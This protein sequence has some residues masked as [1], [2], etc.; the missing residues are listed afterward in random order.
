[1]KEIPHGRCKTS[2]EHQSFQALLKAVKETIIHNGKTAQE[3]LEEEH[4]KNRGTPRE[5]INTPEHDAAVEL[6]DLM[7]WILI[8][9]F[10]EH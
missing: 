3:F 1:M 8:G 9:D 6:V 2:K 10:N 4:Q 7:E 5:Q